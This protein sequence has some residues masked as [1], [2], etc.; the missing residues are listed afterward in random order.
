MNRR[1]GPKASAKQQEAI[2]KEFLAPATP[3]LREQMRARIQTYIDNALIEG[4]DFTDLSE[5]KGLT[6][7]IACKFQ[8]EKLGCWPDM[9]LFHLTGKEYKLVKSLK[10]LITHEVKNRLH[11]AKIVIPDEETPSSGSKKSEQT[12]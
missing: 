2:E 5:R 9:Q 4:K 3:L 8:E 1:S 6:S 7:K 10:D 12:P 11:P